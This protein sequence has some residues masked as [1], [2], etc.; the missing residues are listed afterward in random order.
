[1]LSVCAQW[2]VAAEAVE[3]GDGRP[4]LLAYVGGQL[5]EPFQ[6]LAAMYEKK[7]GVKVEMIFNNCGSLLS[8]LEMSRKGDIFI[9]GGVEFVEKV[10]QK[11]NAAEVSEP[12]AYH[13]P[14]IITPKGNPAGIADVRDLAKPGV[15][16]LMPDA[17][18]TAIGADAIK[19][20]DKLGIIAEVEKNT[21]AS[22]ATPSHVLAAMLMGQGNAAVVSYNV[23]PKAEDK[24]NVVR[25][26]PKVNVVGSIH[27]VV[28][29]FSEHLSQAADF[30]SFLAKS[31]PEVFEAYGF[32]P[33]P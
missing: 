30:S 6:Q 22:L 17:K 21:V 31:G 33:E 28:L 13:V 16:L 32:K 29:S 11:G 15:K 23:I 27:C 8:Q 5:K 14:V 2:A 12:L 19:V 10:R 18:A 1:V 20:F 9:A 26:D 25:I 7:T 24:I 3:N 4:T